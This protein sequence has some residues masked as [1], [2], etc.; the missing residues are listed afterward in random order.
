MESY[1]NGVPVTEQ[2]SWTLSLELI[3]QLANLLQQAT[4]YYLKGDIENAFFRMKTVRMRIIQNLKEDKKNKERTKCFELEAEFVKNKIIRDVNLDG[5]LDNKDRR[6]IKENQM[7]IYEEYNTLI[8][9]LLEKYGY[10]IRKREDNTR[11]SV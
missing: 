2:V 11:I 4:Y 1:D 7:R 6:N 8:M 10:L 3:K 5:V 9:D